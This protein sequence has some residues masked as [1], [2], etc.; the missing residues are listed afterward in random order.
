M[1]QRFNHLFDRLWA[2]SGKPMLEI[3]KPLSEWNCTC[4]PDAYDNLVD[5]NGNII[6]PQDYANYWVIQE[7]RF[8]PYVGDKTGE[9]SDIG[10]VDTLKFEIAMPGDKYDLVKTA[11]SVIIGDK[12]YGLNNIRAFPPNDPVYVIMELIEND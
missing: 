4:Q 1:K 5:E 10:F 8:I 6:D 11:F 7:E 9:F 3:I 12:K 2:V